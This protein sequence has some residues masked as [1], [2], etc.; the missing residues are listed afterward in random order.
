MA[1]ALAV[2]AMKSLFFSLD[3]SMKAASFSSHCGP[4]RIKGASWK[5]VV[6][7][8]INWVAKTPRPFPGDGL[9]SN[10]LS[11]LAPENTISVFESE[12]RQ[13]NVF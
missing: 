10:I 1:V 4:P 6:P 11:K 12:R 9:T 13:T 7:F 2:R 3:R 8:L 5:I